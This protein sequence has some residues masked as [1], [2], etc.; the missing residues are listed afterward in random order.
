MYQL[1]LV[2]HV[3]VDHVDIVIAHAVTVECAIPHVH[4]VMIHIPI[5]CKIDG[6]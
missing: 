3:V 2:P 5:K 1:L 6:A 4:S